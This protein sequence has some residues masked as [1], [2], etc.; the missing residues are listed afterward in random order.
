MILSCMKLS[1]LFM[2]WEE[3]KVDTLW[4]TVKKGKNRTL[5]FL[6]SF[7]CSC[8]TCCC[9]ADSDMSTADGPPHGEEPMWTP[10][11]VV[12]APTRALPPL[13]TG[14]ATSSPR[15]VSGLSPNWALAVN[16]PSIGTHLS[17]PVYTACVTRR[18]INELLTGDCALY[19]R[20]QPPQPH[21]LL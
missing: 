10:G 15:P 17:P 16:G 21:I 13:A 12:S 3:S 19:E 18:V 4:W 2:L 6:C 20:K 11:L 7:L 1:A 14:C 9:T 5:Y 8:D